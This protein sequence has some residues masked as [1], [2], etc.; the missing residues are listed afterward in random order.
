MHVV[1][2]V[3]LSNARAGCER[4]SL[5]CA[6]SI[7]LLDPHFLCMGQSCVRMQPS[8]CVQ[9][10]LLYPLDQ[11]PSGGALCA[12]VL[13]HP[14]VPPGVSSWR[15]AWECNTVTGPAGWPEHLNGA[16]TCCPSAG[17]V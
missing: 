6:L 12:F 15:D 13:W 11:F 2:P 7:A 8:G 16:L 1:S 3:A 9:Q 14:S 17:E 10:C 5:V 4:D